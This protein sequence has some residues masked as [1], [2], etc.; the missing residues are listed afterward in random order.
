LPDTPPADG[1]VFS[2]TGADAF[3]FTID[4]ATGAVAPQD[5]FTPALDDAWD[6]NE[7]HV[8]EVTQVSDAGD[9]SAPV[10]LDLWFET[11]AEGVL[12]PLDD[13]PS[14]TGAPDPAEPDEPGTPDDPV[15][16]LPST[17]ETLYGLTGPDAQLF[18]IDPVTGTVTP[19][20]WFL[21]S[22]DD[23]WDVNEDNIYE[24]TRTTTPLDGNEPVY[25][26]IWLEVTPDDQ[27]VP[28][29]GGAT[30][31]AR[32]FDVTQVAD[33]EFVPQDDGAA[34]DTMSDVFV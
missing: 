18:V 14:D 3:L 16:P 10:S 4:P 2:L 27:L 12:T 22:Y 19:Q 23:A 30:L 32:L 20:D 28:V 25:E 7:D 26:N 24:I 8:Y 33:Q 13:A 6:Q 15:D 17:G 31:M 5:W 29:A 9:G 1:T 11:T 21:P 34:E